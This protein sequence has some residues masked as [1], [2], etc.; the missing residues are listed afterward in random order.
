MIDTAYSNI[1]NIVRY[2]IDH[3]IGSFSLWIFY[4]DIMNVFYQ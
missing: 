2:L 3:E 1:N 4:Y